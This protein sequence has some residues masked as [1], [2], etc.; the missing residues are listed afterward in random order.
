MSLMRFSLI[1]TTF[2]LIGI[3][4]LVEFNNVKCSTRNPD[5]L[6]YEYCFLKSVNRTYKYLS[7]KCHLSQLPITNAWMT[8]KIIK[9]DSRNIFERFNATIDVCKFMK[10][11][12]NQLANILFNSF[13]DYTN[14][15]HTCPINHDIILEKLPVQHVNNML[16]VTKS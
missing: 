11:R 5:F 16:Y 7:V 13:A 3:T 4:A 15:N 8:Y 14:V 12:S 1:F 2:C 10:D 9:R 6:N